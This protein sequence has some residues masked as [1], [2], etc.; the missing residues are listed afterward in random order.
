M[1]PPG[2]QILEI[3]NRQCQPTNAAV[4]ALPFESTLMDLPESELHHVQFSRALQNEIP[5]A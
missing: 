4:V 3:I 2:P 1:Q 5:K